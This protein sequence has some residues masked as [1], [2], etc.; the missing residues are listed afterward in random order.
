MK[1]MLFCMSC[2]PREPKRK[3]KQKRS[4][5]RMCSRPLGGTSTLTN[6]QQCNPENSLRENS[7]QNQKQ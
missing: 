4:D 6:K 2:G 1:A 3:E 5:E 7:E